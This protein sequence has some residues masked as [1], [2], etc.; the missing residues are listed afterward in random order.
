MAVSLF[1][2]GMHI[3]RTRA[4]RRIFNIKLYALTALK[5]AKLHI[6]QT[7]LMKEYFSSVGVADK[8]KPSLLHY[9][10]YLSGMHL[11]FSL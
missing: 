1:S 4:L 3:N 7:A 10:L 11:A 9:F 2:G 6:N 5:N 8:T